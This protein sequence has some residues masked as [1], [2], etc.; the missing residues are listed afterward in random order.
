MGG[1]GG[2]IMSGCGILGGDGGNGADRSWSAVAMSTAPLAASNEPP[3]RITTL[4]PVPPEAAL[5]PAENDR[6]PPCAAPLEPTCSVMPPA[7]DCAELPVAICTLPV[8]P[9]ADSSLRRRTAPLP[10]GPLPLLMATA[11][12]VPPALAPARSVTAP[13][14]PVLDAAPAAM[15]I[16]PPAPATAEPPARATPPPPHCCEQGPCST[17]ACC[18]GC[19]VT[20]L[21]LTVP[22]TAA[23]S[24]AKQ[25]SRRCCC[26]RHRALTYPLWHT[27]ARSR[28]RLAAAE[29][30]IVHHRGHGDA[31]AGEAARVTPCCASCGAARQHDRPPGAARRVPPDT[32]VQQHRPPGRARRVALPALREDAAGGG[33]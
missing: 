8:G 27:A 3:V 9:A 16:A 7:V 23:G 4:P 14:A 30:R 26:V 5:A 6:L 32:A 31:G 11:P 17:A 28:T 22:P 12:P 20:P 25:P 1:F 15:L 24:C 19:T 33:E 18:A 10:A 29:H 13:P 21:Q 2:G